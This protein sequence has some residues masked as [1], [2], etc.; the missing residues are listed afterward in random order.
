MSI[1]VNI[2][3]KVQTNHIDTLLPFDSVSRMGIGICSPHRLQTMIHSDFLTMEH[4]TEDKALLS[5]SVN[6][7]VTVL[8]AAVYAGLIS[9]SCE[10]ILGLYQ[11]KF[12]RLSNRQ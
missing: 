9:Q 2:D 7:P 1:K 6:K 8:T 11:M 4:E 3:V 5:S 10:R 12:C